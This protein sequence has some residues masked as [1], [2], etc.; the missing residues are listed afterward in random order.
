MTC[1]PLLGILLLAS[2][3]ATQAE[4]AKSKRPPSAPNERLQTAAVNGVELA[5]TIDG[6]GPPLL[7]VHRF[8]SSHA[9]WSKQLALYTKHFKVIAVDLRGHGGSTNP[10]R[11]YSHREAAA[12]LSALLEKLKVEPVNAIGVSGGS[13][14]LLHLALQHPEQVKRLVLLGTGNFVPADQRA[15]FNMT[16]DALPPEEWKKLR[17]VHTRGDDQIRMLFEQFKTYVVRDDDIAFTPPMLAKIAAPS[18]LVQAD[19]DKLIPVTQLVMM[20]AAMPKS[21]LWVIPSSDTHLPF[22]A[23][24]PEISAAAVEF[25]TRDQSKLEKT[26]RVH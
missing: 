2:A 16:A 15:V 6:S 9:E 1:S 17:A 22:D 14:V 4:A 8:L 3:C 26:W 18:L 13:I 12:D 11:L 21:H 19:G 23:M 7:L 25:F 5:Y 20:A 10:S 24:Q